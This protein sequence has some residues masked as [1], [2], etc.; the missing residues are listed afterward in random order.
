MYKERFKKYIVFLGVFIITLLSTLG[1]N[2]SAD[3]S[4]T[5]YNFI[6]KGINYL[7]VR[8]NVN[9]SSTGKGFCFNTIEPIMIKEKTEYYIDIFDGRGYFNDL[10][11]V[12]YDHNFEIVFEFRAEC[13]DNPTRYIY[14]GDQG[15]QYISF[16]GSIVYYED[17]NLDIF[18]NL[19]MYEAD[20]DVSN[21][22]IIDMYYR[23]ENDLV[24][25]EESCD[26]YTNASDP[27]TIDELNEEIKVVDDMDGDMTDKK[28]IVSDNYSP[29]FGKVGV[30][31]VQYF[32]Q[33]TALNPA[34]LTVRVHVLDDISPVITGDDFV[35][36]AHNSNTTK[37]D[38]Q[39]LL[40]ASDN[41]LG[42]ITDAI[43]IDSDNFTGNESTPGSYEIVFSVSDGEQT[44][45]YPVT[46]EVYYHDIYSPVISG[47]LEFEVGNNEN[48]SVEEL[49]SRLEI[50]D[51]MSTEFTYN[52]DDGY[53]SNI[54]RVGTYYVILDVFDDAGNC[55]QVILKISIKDKIPPVFMVNVKNVYLKVSEND[56]TT[57]DIMTYLKKTNNLHKDLEYNVVYDEYTENKNTPGEYRIVF[58]NNDKKT[59]V[60]VHV[61]EK[62]YEAPNEVTF[63]ERIKTLFENLFNSIRS[64][65]SSIF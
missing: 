24:V 9:Y 20:V 22:T 31:E 37:D 5:K 52:I 8:N 32:V 18:C 57:L 62:L 60:L 7:D 63:I 25:V 16:S 33:D 38:I 48:I 56:V 61:M 4:T 2:V 59:E 44:T 39:A 29:N 27:I 19:V 46:I 40:S 13:K 15:V 54:G 35:R 45:V 65:F 6:P 53:T 17:L 12:I 28:T 58:E 23:G 36:V 34:S 64:F 14:N 1:I 30:W 55:S 50:T 43:K 11:F 47:S 10:S 51:D 41:N 21:A 3:D 26:F 49:I 42:D